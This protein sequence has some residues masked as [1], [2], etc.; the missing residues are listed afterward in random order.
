LE[1][2]ELLNKLIDWKI[3]SSEK[4]HLNTPALSFETPTQRGFAAQADIALPLDLKTLL[5]TKLIP[6]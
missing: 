4:S 2:T 5:L 1:L 6:T 3:V